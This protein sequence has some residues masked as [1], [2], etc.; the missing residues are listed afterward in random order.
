MQL[1][2]NNLTADQED[3]GRSGVQEQENWGRSGVQEQQEWGRSGVQEP[4]PDLLLRH[5]WTP[6]IVPP[7]RVCPGWTETRQ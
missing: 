5:G 2:V 3:W 1:N 6:N 7:N 4:P